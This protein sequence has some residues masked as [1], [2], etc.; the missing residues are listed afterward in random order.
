MVTTPANT[1]RYTRQKFLPL[2]SPRIAIMGVYS[3]VAIIQIILYGISI[4]IH[5][6][7]IYLLVTQSRRM[8]NQTMLLVNLS[9]SEILFVICFILKWFR[10]REIAPSIVSNISEVLDFVINIYFFNVLLCISI[11]RLLGAIFPLKHRVIVTKHRL[12]TI[13]TITWI[14]CVVILITGITL[15]L[16]KHLISIWLI[17][18][19]VK[20]YFYIT[21]DCLIVLIFIV[22]YGSILAKIIRRRKVAN[23]TR[24][25]NAQT[26]KNLIF[27]NNKRFFKVAGLIIFTYIIFF[28]IPGVI[29]S[30]FVHENAVKEYIFIFF[31]FGIIVDPLV[32]IFLQPE[33]RKRLKLNICSYFCRRRNCRNLQSP[34]PHFNDTYL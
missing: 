29:L 3:L 19:R 8:T 25:T 31:S 17:Y 5:S 20:L 18:L 9:S 22:T 30:L 15:V 10:A 21:I 28:L 4:I 24:Q 11:D 34:Q 32:Y 1:Q 23:A 16:T 13:L 6:L 2:Y 12:K 7:G 33:L 27:R 26:R 14:F